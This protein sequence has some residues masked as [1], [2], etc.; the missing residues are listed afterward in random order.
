MLHYFLFI[1]FVVDITQRCVYIET[2]TSNAILKSMLHTSSLSRSQWILLL[3]Q[4]IARK[5][6]SYECIGGGIAK[7]F[8]FFLYGW[9]CAIDVNLGNFK[10]IMCNRLNFRLEKKQL[11]L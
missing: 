8:L 7:I 1:S 2:I 4:Y 5:V 10:I 6:H 3:K 9:D 11:D